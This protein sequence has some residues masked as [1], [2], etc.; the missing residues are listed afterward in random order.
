MQQQHHWS[1]HQLL[2]A[3]DCKANIVLGLVL[4]PPRKVRGPFESLKYTWRVYYDLAEALFNL[5]PVIQCFVERRVRY[6]QLQRIER[7]T[8]ALSK[9]VGLAIAQSSLSDVLYRDWTLLRL[10]LVETSVGETE[11][12]HMHPS[13]SA[14]A[15]F[16][17]SDCT[18]FRDAL[19]TVL[20]PVLCYIVKEYTLTAPEKRLLEYTFPGQAPS[21]K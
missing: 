16:H 13:I 18:R 5:A 9:D 2:D 3:T 7:R 17:S 20:P 11:E 15:S 1:T 4:N 8:F 19:Q 14:E 6:H 10:S 12:P 21:A